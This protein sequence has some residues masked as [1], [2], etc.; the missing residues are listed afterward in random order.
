ML[1][2]LPD[3]TVRLAKLSQTRQITDR[4]RQIKASIDHFDFFG[5]ALRLTR[6]YESSIQSA[7][8]FN[9]RE[10]EDLS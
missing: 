1:F 7:G 10:L 6:F 3:A 8:L 2:E 5:T 4:P 9:R